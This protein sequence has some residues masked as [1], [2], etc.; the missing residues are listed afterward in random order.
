[1]DAHVNQ[2]L[3][4]MSSR[5]A[6][7]AG[8]SE[9]FQQLLCSMTDW[10]GLLE[11]ASSEGLVGLFY[12][13]VLQTGLEAK[14]PPS[15]SRSLRHTHLRNQIDYARKARAVEQMAEAFDQEGLRFLLLQGMAITERIYP[16]SG[17]RP[18]SD[19]DLLI[20][21]HHLPQAQR[22]LIRLGYLPLHRYPPT[23]A[24]RD[25]CVDLH[26]ELAY[27]S[28]VEPQARN[29][30]RVDD[31]LLWQ[32]AI[33]WRGNL[34]GAWIPSSVDQIILLCA[35]LQKHSFG[36]L[37]WFVDIGRLLQVHAQE[38]AP[39]FLRERAGQ[40]NLEK[41]FHF[42]SSYLQNVIGQSW[43]FDAPPAAAPRLNCVEQ[44][45][46][47]LLTRNRRIDGMGD[48]LYLL[49]IEDPLVRLRFLAQLVWP[50]RSVM[51]E[52]VGSS[53]PWNLGIGYL[54]RVGRFSG[55]AFRLLGRLPFR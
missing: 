26:P 52:M 21:R 38:D 4:L 48:L 35:H 24:K 31:T 53:S 49:A 40:L 14:L 1:M 8:G 28:R 2:R 34:P 25:I 41:P 12:E 36:R 17:A 33:P 11:R 20:P 47:T 22:V 43:P 6:C 50:Q 7:N 32:S 23:Y 13:Q 27:L 39:T 15:V 16:S 29:P 18:L 42:V 51:E 30:L 19:I 46:L 44:R 10:S 9:E 54:S 45:L 3:L 5:L 55:Q 37:I